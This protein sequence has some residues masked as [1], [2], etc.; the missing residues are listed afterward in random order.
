MMSTNMK[1]PALVPSLKD[2]DWHFILRISLIIAVFVILER[3]ILHVGQLPRTF[4]S[5]PYLTNGILTH[6]GW[7][8]GM[9]LMLYGGAVLVLKPLRASWTSYSSSPALRIMIGAC[10]ILLAWPYSTYDYNFYFDDSH[11]DGRV[12][13]AML[14]LLSCWRAAVIPI[15]LIVVTAVMHQFHYPLGGDSLSEQ[16]LFVKILLLCWLCFLFKSWIGKKGEHDFLFLTLIVLASAYWTCGFGKLRMNWISFGHIYHLL[17]AT[18]ANG[19]L[20]FLSPDQIGH[21][22][23]WLAKLDWLMRFFVVIVEVG[24]LFVWWRRWTVMT[25]LAFWVCFHLGVFALSGILFWKWIVL[26]VGLLIFMLQSKTAKKLPFFNPATFVVSVLFIGAG[27]YLFQPTNLSWYDSPVSYA[28]RFEGQGED[29]NVYEISP[30][31]FNPYDYQFT[32]GAFRYLSESPTIPV[33]WGAVFDRA[34]AEEV[35]KV[36]NLD[37]IRALEEELNQITFNPEKAQVMDQFIRRWA[38]RYATEKRAAA[39]WERLKAPPQLV[40]FSRN[41]AY[42]GQVTLTKIDLYQVTT[43]FDGKYRELEKKH[44]REITL[45]SERR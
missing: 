36:R 5:Q 37:D 35:L 20:G 21:M 25:F 28:F 10:V 18:Y 2:P 45:P 42:H 4:Y 9:A 31:L 32:M 1:I 41:N 39:S 26:E 44:L 38:D 43:L 22:S 33:V 7:L 8:H 14:G 12:A 11:W 40:T 23:Q 13:V 24:A 17:S 30:Q 27:K 3:W 15:F 19:W 29:G 6:I 16:S 34:V